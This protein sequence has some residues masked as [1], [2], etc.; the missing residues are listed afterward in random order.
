[1]SAKG[2]FKQP[3]PGQEISRPY[4]ER[5]ERMGEKVTNLDDP[6]ARKHF[7]VVIIKPEEVESVCLADPAVARRQRYAFQSSTG[8]WNL[9]ETWP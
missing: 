1:M 8:D 7:R 3:P 2:S 6:V 4:N 9:E 5:E